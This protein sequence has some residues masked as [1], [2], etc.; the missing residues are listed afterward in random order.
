MKSVMWSELTLGAVP[1]CMRLSQ[2][3]LLSRRL[4]LVRKQLQ[5]K[6]DLEKVLSVCLKRSLTLIL[7]LHW[8]GFFMGSTRQK[9]WAIGAMLSSFYLV[10]FQYGGTTVCLVH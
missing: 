3:E 5:D 7:L 8:G 10:L 4:E 6:E 9:V 2:V 1:S